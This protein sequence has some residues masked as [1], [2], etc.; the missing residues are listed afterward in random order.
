VIQAAKAG[1]W[2]QGADGVAVAGIP[3]L[4]GEFELVLEIADPSS[5]VGFL[6]GGGFVVLDA[7]VTPELEAEGLARDVIRAVQQARKGAGLEV[8]DRIDLEIDGDPAA[9][10]A[11]EA[12]RELIAGETLAVRL[13][14]GD[15]GGEAGDAIAVGAGSAVTIRVERA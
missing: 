5:A 1:D 15:R 8:G 13:A 2:T 4:D 12:H 9:V 14:V 3:L 7:T 10:A 6:P 11:V